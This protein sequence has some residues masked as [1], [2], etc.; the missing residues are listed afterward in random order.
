MRRVHRNVDNFKKPTGGPHEDSFLRPLISLDA[1]HLPAK[2]WTS[3][4]RS[5]MASS[6]WLKGTGQAAVGPPAVGDGS[7]G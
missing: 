6:D 4:K 2:A 5:S 3:T 7:T 1:R